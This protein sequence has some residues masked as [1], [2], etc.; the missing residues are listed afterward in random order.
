MQGVKLSEN[1]LK[2]MNF[3]EEDNHWQAL[4]KYMYYKEVTNKI[5]K[6]QSIKDRSKEHQLQLKDQIQVKGI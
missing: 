1:E 5:N 4:Q 2:V 6:N 3:W